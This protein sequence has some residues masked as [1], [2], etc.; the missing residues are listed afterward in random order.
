[1]S[2][3]EKF[4]EN[5]YRRQ[6]K[7]QL[8]EINETKFEVSS[9]LYEIREKIEKIQFLNYLLDKANFEYEKHLIVC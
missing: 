8:K 5:L 2:I 7:Y 9:K 1:M 6:F 4:A 3:I